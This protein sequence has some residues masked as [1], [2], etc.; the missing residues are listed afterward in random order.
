MSMCQGFRALRS[1]EG[2]LT[3]M[4]PT[5][6]IIVSHGDQ[7][8]SAATNA[9]FAS[10]HGLSVAPSPSRRRP[11][12]SPNRALVTSWHCGVSQERCASVCGGR[13]DLLAHR[14]PKRFFAI[15]DQRQILTSPSKGGAVALGRNPTSRFS[16]APNSPSRHLSS[17]GALPRT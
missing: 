11:F 10:L 4:W 3:E 5:I 9:R 2:Y 15:L 16:P 1:L 13:G 14:R 6:R 8:T 17:P 7:R 12:H